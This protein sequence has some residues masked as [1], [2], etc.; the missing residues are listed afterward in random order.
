MAV[1]TAT[2]PKDLSTA[3][4]T[5]KHGCCGGEAGEESRTDKSKHVDHD[6]RESAV[7]SKAVKSSCCCGTRN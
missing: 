1:K 6:R 7:P 2:D 3:T 4:E 5:S